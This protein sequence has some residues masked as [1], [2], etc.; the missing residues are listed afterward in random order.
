M[1]AAL[2]RPNLEVLQ[3]AA[4]PLRGLNIDFDPLLEMIGDSPCVLIGEATHGTH[5]F[6][7]ARSELT[8]R[9]IVEKGFQAVAL[10]AD[11]PDAFRV[12]RYVRGANKDRD[13]NAALGGFRRF[14]TWM[15]R[16]RVML[17]FVAWL[18]QHNH[19]QFHDARKTGVYGLDLYSMHASIEAVLKYLDGVD[20]QAARQARNRYGCFEDFGEDSQAYG[21]AASINMSETCEEE[22]LAQLVDLQQ[23]GTFYASLDGHV[24]EDEFF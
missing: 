12:D 16:N 24:A 9:L 20:P 15:W 10:E 1:P 4:H 19:G 17:A 18:R 13:A 5:E 22:V 23:R 14:P 8:K 11:W 3:D 2:T 7:E 21:Y 6:Y